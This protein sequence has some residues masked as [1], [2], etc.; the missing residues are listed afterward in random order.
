MS[1]S[2]LIDDAQQ[3]HLECWTHV[4]H[5]IQEDRATIS[6][7]ETTYT[8]ARCACKRSTFM[9]EELAFQQA[10]WN[11]AT[12]HR[13]HRLLGTVAIEMNGLSDQLF[14]G[15]TFTEDEYSALHIGYFFDE[16]E[17]LLHGRAGAYQVFKTVFGLELMP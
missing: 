2:T 7:L 3:F 13:D 12:I 16:L 1:C 17:D 4:L 14:A 11:G 5:F 9:A 15:A 6:Q 10:F 8:G